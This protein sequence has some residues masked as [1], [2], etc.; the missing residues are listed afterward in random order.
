MKNYS[1]LETAIGFIFLRDWAED[2]AWDIIH[3]SHDMSYPINVKKFQSIILE[4]MS[5]ANGWKS[6]K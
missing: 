4:S 6:G 5:T 1:Y 2:V 3:E